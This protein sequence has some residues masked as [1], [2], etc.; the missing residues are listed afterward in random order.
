MLQGNYLHYSVPSVSFLFFFAIHFVSC[1]EIPPNL[2]YKHLSVAI[3]MYGPLT[4]PPFYYLLYH[5]PWTSPVRSSYA[6][7]ILLSLAP[8]IDPLPSRPA[9][10]KTSC[11]FT[12]V[13][14]L[15]RMTSLNAC[16]LLF[17]LSL[18]ELTVLPCN[19]LVC[20]PI[21]KLHV[22]DPTR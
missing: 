6:E 4:L 13:L 11:W 3:N 7:L 10:P 8:S 15:L 14:S 17:W 9:V 5:L 1:C 20:Q 22:L 2:L 21:P 19:K 18:M 16:C 12:F